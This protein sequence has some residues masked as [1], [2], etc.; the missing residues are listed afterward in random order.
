MKKKQII[1][2]F[3]ILFMIFSY[4]SGRL[5]IAEENHNNQSIHEQSEYP[6]ENHDHQD[7]EHDSEHVDH[8]HHHTPNTWLNPDIKY[9]VK[10]TNFFVSPLVFLTL[11]L[12]IWKERK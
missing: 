1:L 5:S 3:G 11:L 8:D 2:Y 12:L 9:E 6:G 7:L 10:I 4:F